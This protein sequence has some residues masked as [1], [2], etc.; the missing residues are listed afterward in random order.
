LKPNF[1]GTDSCGETKL[2]KKFCY[3]VPHQTVHKNV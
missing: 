3:Y 1:F 2:Q